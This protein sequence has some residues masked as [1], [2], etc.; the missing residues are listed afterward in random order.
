MSQGHEALQRGH[1]PHSPPEASR[2]ATA[3]LLMVKQDFLTCGTCDMKSRETHCCDLP[4]WRELRGARNGPLTG[5]L[6]LES[7]AGMPCFSGGK[8]VLRCMARSLA[9]VGHEVTVLCQATKQ[10]VLLTFMEVRPPHPSCFGATGIPRSP[11][12][13]DPPHLFPSLPPLLFVHVWQPGGAGTGEFPLPGSCSPFPASRGMSCRLE[14][15]PS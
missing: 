12:Q 2:S 1:D 15:F 3:R 13:T 14:S 8:H 10:Q 7:Y 9:R 6:P 5:A 4:K 11:F